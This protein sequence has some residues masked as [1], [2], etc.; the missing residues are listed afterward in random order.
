VRQGKGRQLLRRG[1]PRWVRQGESRQAFTQRKSEVD[2]LRGRAGSFYAEEGRRIAH[3]FYAE[4]VWTA[5]TE[6]LWW[7]IIL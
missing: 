2:V 1:S 4:E 5:H 6:R 7:S 3:T